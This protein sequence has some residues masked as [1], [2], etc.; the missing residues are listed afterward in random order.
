MRKDARQKR[1]AD[2]ERGH[3]KEEGQTD[4]VKGG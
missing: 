2:G 3:R 1:K 4:N